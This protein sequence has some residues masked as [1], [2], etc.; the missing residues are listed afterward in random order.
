MLFEA[1]RAHVAFE[2]SLRTTP[3]HEWS[4]SWQ[5]DA[6][7]PNVYPQYA[8][9]HHA[10]SILV[11]VDHKGGYGWGIGGFK[12]HPDRST[13]ENVDNGKNLDDHA[14]IVPLDPDRRVVGDSN[15]GP[16]ELDFSA[17]LG[18][19]S[20][21]FI[22]TW[23]RECATSHAKCNTIF[24]NNGFGQPAG[25]WFPDRLIKLTQTKFDE[26]CVTITGRIVQK[27]NLSD[28]PPEKASS[29]IN[30][31]SLSHC[32]GPSPE[33]S[34]PLGG[35]MGSVLT[36]S[37]LSDWQKDL[38]I[39]DLPLV[40]QDAIRI[41]T[42]LGFEYLWIDS[43]CILQDSLDDWHVQSAVMGDV[44]KFAWLN[45][46]ALSAKTDYEGF[47][48]YS[49]ETR[50]EFGFRAPFASILGR[51][52]GEKNDNGQ[53]I[54]LLRGRAKLL[55][56]F[57]PDTL[58][59]N[60][61]DPPLFQRGWVYQERNLARRTLGFAKN[62]VHWVCDECSQG[63]QPDWNGTLSSNSLRQTLHT[64]LQTM[65]L[66]A[67]IP[68]NGASPGQSSM[69]SEQAL[70]L[71]K[72][73]DMS[74]WSCV[75]AYTLCKLTKHTDKL[76]AVSSIAREL[77]NTKVIPRRYLAGLWEANL[78]FQLGWITVQGDTTPPRKK[79]GDADYAA[80]SWS[81]ASIE[82]PVQPRFIF[83]SGN[84]LI[85]LADVLAADVAL[86][87]DFTFGSV[88]A[89][90]L[91]ISGRLN[92]VKAIEKKPF[93]S[94]DQSSKSISLTDMTTGEK[95]WFCADTV[96]GRNFHKS[97][98][99]TEKL[100]WMPLT[101]R[102]DTTTLDCTTLV[103]IEVPKEDR[104]A[105]EGEFL[106]PGEKVYRRLGTGNFGRIPSMLRQDKLLLQL[107][108]YPDIQ[109]ENVQ[110]QDLV[111]GFKRQTDGMENFVLI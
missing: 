107:G 81:W 93:Y 33:P 99:G 20:L 2:S 87:T 89:G 21:T 92:S 105:H 4:L 98:T 40:F 64:V 73:F 111:K 45:I 31:L 100:V 78:V 7:D 55:W 90:W 57:S 80:P 11:S 53:E 106:K 1:A 74:W 63:E 43:L 28:F 26:T 36:D 15:T 41:C 61:S 5:V 54:V 25:V 76:I 72:S 70:S 82:A 37:T 50:V 13:S 104:I 101:L 109:R 69:T 85:A 67:N 62:R 84:G 97:G 95:L 19:G 16:P 68:R 94:W 56:N 27:S 52:V 102:F 32:W 83:P 59:T 14:I 60:V 23:I 77:D 103:L 51:S 39:D 35:R 47:I 88:K 44:Y 29:G 65:Q 22:T 86:E 108:S 110:G 12:I 79:V 3:F 48:N 66:V 71:I 34:A 75:T 58:G 49:R 30:Y 10:V 24:G 6:S 46:A 9:P 8:F 38:P 42:S 18:T 17:T 96:E 91:R